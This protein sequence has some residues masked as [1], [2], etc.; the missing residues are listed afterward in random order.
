MSGVWRLVLVSVSGGTENSI[1]CIS[2]IICSP[3]LD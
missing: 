1:N 2:T 3:E